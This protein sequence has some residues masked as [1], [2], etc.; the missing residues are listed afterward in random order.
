MSF[1]TIAQ[2][3]KDILD[4]VKNASGSALS[5]TF[6]YDP[7]Y[8][9]SLGFPYACVVNKT[10]E[11]EALDTANNQT[12]Y[13]FVLRVCDVNSTKTQVEQNIRNCADQLLAELRKRENMTFGGTVDKVYP[14][15]V[16]FFWD[17]SQQT[18]MRVCEITVDVLM[19][20]SI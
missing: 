18:P 16:N 1:I 11:E 7:G 2:K 6:D 19:H 10:A 15:Q 3:L 5:A 9:S 4:T 14:F 12:L 17:N 8:T 20:Y 13:H